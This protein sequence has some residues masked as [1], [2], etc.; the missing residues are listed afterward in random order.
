MPI[1]DRT[2]NRSYQLP[3]VG[4]FLADDVVRLRAA[5]ASIDADVFARYT[6]TEVDTLI[7]NLIAGAPGA[8]NTL[9]EL[10]AA[11]GDDANFAATVTNLLALKANIADVYTKAEADARYVQGSVQ[12]EMVFIATANQSVFTLTTAVINKPSALVTVDGVVQPTSEYSLNMAGTTLT[13]S[14]GVPVGTIVRVLALGVASAGAP[15][16]DTVTTPKLR[17][18]AVTTPKLGDGAVTTPKL[19]DG[20]VT[21]AKLGDGAVTTAK[22][23]SPIAPVISSIN[24]GQLAGTRN[25]IINGGMALDQRNA[26]ASQAITAAAALAYSVDRWYAYCTGANVTGQ[27]VQGATVGQYRYRFTGAASVTAIGFGQRIEQLNSADLAGTTATLSVDLANSLLTTVTWTAFYATTADTFGTLASPT[28]TQIATGTFT[29]NSTVTRYST[30]I[31]VPAAATTGIE[32]VFTVGAQTSG[33]WTIG[34]VQLERGTVATPFERRSYGQELALCQRYCWVFGNS[35]NAPFGSGYETASIG[36]A[37]AALPVTMRATPTFF[38]TVASTFAIVD[39]G[40][41]GRSGTAIALD[42]AS[43]TAVVVNLTCSGT[44]A[45]SGCMLRTSTATATMTFTAEL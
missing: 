28:R 34:D 20:A 12:T 44:N 26:G 11:L 7:N 10:A 17:D 8:L 15:A 42:L 14:E 25:R 27:Q 29:V 16:D 5:L 39:S 9:D 21:T 45:N 41:A 4:N 31:S 23:A 33:T 32:I 40:S 37:S 1:D 22:L 18:G 36:K 24:D 2:T 30:N 13:L 35:D 6:K 38:S 43:P 3:N 19:G